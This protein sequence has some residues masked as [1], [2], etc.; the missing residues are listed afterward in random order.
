MNTRDR[1][2][3]ALESNKGQFISGEEL[4]GLIGVSRNSVWKSVRDLKELG[5]AIESVT[6]KGYRLSEESDIISVQ[7]ISSM[8]DDKSYSDH[9]EVYEELTS[10]ND[11]AKQKAISG[12]TH[13]SVIIAKSQTK[14]RGH[15]NKDFSSPE[16][17]IYLSILLD[18]GEPAYKN[19]SMYAAVVVADV[20]EEITGREAKIK[21]INN[22]YIDGEKVCGILTETMVDMETGEP[23]TYIVGIG[24]RYEVASRN[25]VIAG[26]LNRIYKPTK[27]Y[28]PDKVIKLYEEGLMYVNESVSFKVYIDGH[29]EIFEAVI[30]GVSEDGCLI[31]LQDDRERL[32]RAGQIL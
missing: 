27:Y 15:G 21:W 22:I 5:Y 11:I 4:A 30:K 32:L 13:G 17:G 20:L 10:T 6:N 7:G 31:V 23:G 25:K 2:L 3:S 26:I 18:S 1:V 16:G 19:I 12:M 14:G 8:L 24:I 28:E 29:E 9:I